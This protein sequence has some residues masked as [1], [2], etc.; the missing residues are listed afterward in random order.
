MKILKN[1]P[2]NL[3]QF[4]LKRNPKFTAQSLE[5]KDFD[6]ILEQIRRLRR[7]RCEEI[8]VVVKDP[9]VKL[10]ISVDMYVEDDE[11]FSSNET[12]RR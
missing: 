6:L 9:N 2:G 1:R 10:T 11:I 12:T 3:S 4:T 8:P 5:N 7:C